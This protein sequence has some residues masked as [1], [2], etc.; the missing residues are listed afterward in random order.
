MTTPDRD[1]YR[2]WNRDWAVP[3]GD[4]LKEWLEERSISVATFATQIDVPAWQLEEFF[5]GDRILTTDLIDKLA[6]ATGISRRLWLNLEVEY[7]TLKPRD[8]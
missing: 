1:P 6:K 7:R 3:P 2:F 4:L 5:I 8:Q